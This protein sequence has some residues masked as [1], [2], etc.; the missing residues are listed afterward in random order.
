MSLLVTGS[1]GI[2]TVET[3]TDKAVAVPGGSAFYFSLAAASFCKTRLIGVV[4]EDFPDEMRSILE[5]AGVDL[6]GLEVRKGG[7][8][9]RWHGKYHE[10]M[11]E[12]D[13]I[14][15]Q[16]NVL[17]EHGPPMPAA[18]RDSKYVF[19]ANTDPA[20]QLELLDQLDDPDLV[21]CDTMNLWIENARDNLM[22]VF[23]KV[24][25]V[26][27]ND[28]E[29]QMLIDEPNPVVAGQEILKLGPSFVVIKK[30]EHG[31]V[32]FGQDYVAPFPAF[33][34]ETVVDPT[35]AGDCFAGGMMGYL[36]SQ[37]TSDID[38]LT[39][40]RAVMYGTV[41]ASFAIESFSV[42]RLQSLTL[43]DVETRFAR[44]RDMLT[45]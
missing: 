44:V 11:N 2:D 17:G 29:A 45:L 28:S 13:T 40:R 36:A 20:L 42:T 18:F 5:D 27:L 9:F 15:V 32:V 37:G 23:K 4:G 39:L 1:I 8:T 38:G 10:N 26:V 14:D 31:S 3:P 12:R 7:K 24:D 41:V 6:A 25:G 43:R 33:A 22:K 16:L 19:L 21:V 30:G 35:G 34:A